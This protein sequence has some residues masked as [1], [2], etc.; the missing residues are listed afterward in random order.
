MFPGTVNSVH[1]NQVNIIVRRS[2]RRRSTAS[3]S[4]SLTGDLNLTNSFDHSHRDHS[5]QHYG[6]NH[7]THNSLN[8]PRVFLTLEGN[9]TSRV[10]EPIQ[11]QSDTSHGDDTDSG[12]TVATSHHPSSLQTREGNSGEAGSPKVVKI[13][14]L[15]QRIEACCENCQNI[16]LDRTPAKGIPL[17]YLQASAPLWPHESLQEHRPLMVDGTPAY[18]SLHRPEFEHVTAL[19]T[20]AE[21]DWESQSDDTSLGSGSYY[22]ADSGT[23]GTRDSYRLGNPRDTVENTEAL[24]GPSEDHRELDE[25][26]VSLSQTTSSDRV[27]THVLRDAYSD[28]ST[29]VGGDRVTP[30]SQSFFTNSTNVQNLVTEYHDYHT[31]TIN[32]IQVSGRNGRDSTALDRLLAHVAHGAVHDSAERGLDAPKCHPETR[33]AVRADIMSWV[34]HGECDETPKRFLWLSGPAGSGKTAIAGTIAD[35]CYKQDL[36]A[37]SFF[38]S[39]FAGSGNRRSKTSFIATLVYGLI[40]HESIVGLK[41]E[42]LAVSERD[43]IV[44]ERH[45]YQQVEELVLKPLRKVARRSDPRPWPAVIIVDGLDECDGDMDSSS[46]SDAQT[47]ILSALSRACEDPSF[48]FRIII[49]SRPEPVI[50]HFFSTSACPALHIFLDSK[51]DPDS[52]IRLFLEAMLSGIRRRYNL[53]TNW[54]S[55]E[56]VDHLVKE[57]SGQ[58]IYAATAIRSLDNPSLGSPQQ[59]LTRLL[60]SRSLDNSKPFA[61]LDALYNRILRA[62]PDPL[63]AVKWIRFIDY[64]PGSH[65]GALYLKCVLE[66]YPR[67]AEYVLGALTSLVGLISENGDPDFHFY[68]KSLLDFLRDPQRSGDL[69]INEESLDQFARDRYYQTLRARGPQSRAAG[70]PPDPHFPEFP[71]FFCANLVLFMD[72]DHMYTSDDVEWWLLHLDQSDLAHTIPSAFSS[73]HQQC[74]WHRCLP[75]CG[76]WRKG[77][78]RYCKEHGWRVPTIGEMSRDRL[79]AVVISDCFAPPEGYDSQSAERSKTGRE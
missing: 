43:P 49:A 2:R 74:K 48:P 41:D 21:D 23:A 12:Q 38:F 77:I 3:S 63:L 29:G 27:H 39:A 32:S 45:L 59:Q 34:K 70:G 75:A 17:G 60:E 4:A 73:I 18:R 78:L 79:K 66:S 25:V 26:H 44:F 72:L 64:H 47:E 52:D 53:P 51:Y 22:S 68:H 31:T 55:Q 56:V 35:E 28:N 19:D 13:E 7:T 54:V 65:H 61:S 1:I 76:V 14:T 69:H 67:E 50:R 6:D 33:T 40:Q 15:N 57:A 42:V 46:K 62:S 20:V 30:S 5:V 58:I 24:Q 9:T 71:A 11:V 37:A 36:L 10:G 16:V 8:P